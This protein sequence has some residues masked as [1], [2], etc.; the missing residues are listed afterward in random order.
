MQRPGPLAAL[1]LNGSPAQHQIGR[2]RFHRVHH[3]GQVTGVEGGVGV[4]DADDVAARRQQSGV[5]RGPEATLRD[6]H[7][8][9][10]VR[11]GDGGRLVGRTVVRDDGPEAVRHPGQHPGQ[12]ACLV[13]ARQD[14][15]DFHGDR[16]Y[17]RGW[18]NEREKGLIGPYEG[19]TVLAGW[20]GAVRRAG[21]L[22]ACAY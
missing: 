2:V 7:H 6:V 18:A 3:Q 10:P 22:Q 21:W 19:V 20:P 1:A 5:A 8:A 12:S 11:R 15:I 14:D 4:H 13:E 9:R 16:Q 17:F